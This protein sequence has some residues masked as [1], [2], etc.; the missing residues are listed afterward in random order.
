MPPEMNTHVHVPGVLVTPSSCCTSA[1]TSIDR[2]T[3]VLPESSRTWYATTT[4]L[5]KGF[6]EGTPSTSGARNAVFTMLVARGCCIT[7][8]S[9][10]LVL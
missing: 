10:P 8:N 4:V 6:T 3:C 2:S 7:P 5:R 9:A 1:V